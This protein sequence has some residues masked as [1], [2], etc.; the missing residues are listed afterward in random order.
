MDQAWVDAGA[1]TI[2]RT[3]EIFQDW[4]RGRD[5]LLEGQDYWELGECLAG[6][7]GFRD[8]LLVWV[9]LEG[10]TRQEPGDR[11]QLEESL[12]E[13]GRLQSCKEGRGKEG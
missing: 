9:L 11:I 10:A 4:L 2:E 3:S 13:S 6:K 12:W 8:K 7:G 5:C 1:W